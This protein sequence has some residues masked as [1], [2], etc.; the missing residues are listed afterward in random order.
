[1]K[2]Y[3]GIC[4]SH[5]AAASLMVNGEII[6]AVMEERFTNVKNFQGYPK[7][8]IDYC[9]QYAKKKNFKSKCFCK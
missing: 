9:I 3:L 2:V 7:Q 5:N 4:C 6:I 8:S 1:M